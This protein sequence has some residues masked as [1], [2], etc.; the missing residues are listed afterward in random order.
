MISQEVGATFNQMFLWQFQR[1][2][3]QDQI[4]QNVGSPTFNQYVVATMITQEQVFQKCCFSDSNV[5]QQGADTN[6]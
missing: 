2:N 5:L 6:T 1:M 4:F 3:T